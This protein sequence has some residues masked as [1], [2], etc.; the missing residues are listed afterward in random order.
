M[1]WAVILYTTATVRT[2][3][4]VVNV[5]LELA[6][7]VQRLGNELDDRNWGSIP[8]SGKKSFLSMALRPAVDIEVSYPGSR[9]RIVTLM[10]SPCSA[11]VK[12]SRSDL[13][14]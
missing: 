1:S 12:N 3:F 11:E 13:Q 9:G 7:S 8:V 14:M 2:V 10:S 5:G 6:E 4:R